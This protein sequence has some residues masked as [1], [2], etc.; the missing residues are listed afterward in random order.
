MPGLKAAVVPVTPFQQNC[1]TLW[2]EASGRGAVVDPGGDVE[3]ILDAVAKQG[4]QV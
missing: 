3:R 1:S 2:D 4:V